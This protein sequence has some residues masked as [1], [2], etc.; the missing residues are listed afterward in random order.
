M[1]FCV[2][3]SNSLD[4]ITAGISILQPTSGELTH[5]AFMSSAGGSRCL[6]PMGQP[7]EPVTLHLVM[8]TETA[9]PFSAD[10]KN[11]IFWDVF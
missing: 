6:R 2:M 1:Y 4:R 11:C 7:R 8:S 3:V 5:R 9:Q 10:Y